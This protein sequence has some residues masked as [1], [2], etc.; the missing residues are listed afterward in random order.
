VA[1]L[2]RFGYVT[3][4][5]STAMISGN[6]WS[7]KIKAFQ[8][9]ADVPQTGEMDLATKQ[10]MKATRCGVPDKTPS[11]HGHSH[12]H[13]HRRLRVKRQYSV[14]KWPRNELTYCKQFAGQK[15]YHQVSL[16]RIVHM[17]NC[18]TN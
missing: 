8:D 1:Y 15:S 2:Q 7:D 16:W 14:Y 5:L 3:E 18:M 12:R 9:M 4:D 11:Q 13:R 10:A 17:D 6:F